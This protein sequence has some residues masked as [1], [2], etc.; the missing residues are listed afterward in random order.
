MLRKKTKTKNLPAFSEMSTDRQCR[1]NDESKQ[2]SKNKQKQI[3][4]MIAL[5]NSGTPVTIPCL[6]S[7]NF[8][9]DIGTS[10]M[11]NVQHHIG[12]TVL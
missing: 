8:T 3:M 4:T 12:S 10:T 1:Q 5:C 11:Y 6:L 2:K 7:S 9:W